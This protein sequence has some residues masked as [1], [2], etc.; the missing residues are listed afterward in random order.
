MDHVGPIARSVDDVA[1][2]FSVLSGNAIDAGA[3]ARLDGI[4]AGFPDRYFSTN[5]SP[6]T[7]QVL[8]R[9]REW[10]R[11][12]GA[13][14]VE[15]SLPQTFEAGV[16]AGVVTMYAEMAAVHRERFEAMRERY[17]P[18]LACLLE[19]GLR[20]GAADYLRA[21]Q[22][23]RIAA[24][25]LS[26]VFRSVDCLVT[27][28]T[29]GPAPHG[30]EATGDWTFNLPFSATGHPALSVPVALSAGELPLGL[31]LVGAHR[32]EA[33]LIRVGRALEAAAAFP[34]SPFGRKT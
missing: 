12:A 19:A 34:P 10:L 31:Q 23:R 14:L 1:L 27:P 18:K 2:G 26:S 5:A 28:S 17:S 6:E 7:A 33:V 22:I 21:Q 9:A 29:P 3:S 24:A 30:L 20:V 11:A 32:H 25:E 15:V 4:V 8:E 16:D 13:R